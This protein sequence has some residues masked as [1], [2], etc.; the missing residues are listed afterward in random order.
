MSQ[1]K[2]WPLSSFLSVHSSATD[3]HISSEKITC[4]YCAPT[5]NARKPQIN[6]WT[7]RHTGVRPD[8]YNYC[9]ASPIPSITNNEQ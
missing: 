6:T 2:N 5:K 1:H 4:L 3:R 7:V 9:F 8:H